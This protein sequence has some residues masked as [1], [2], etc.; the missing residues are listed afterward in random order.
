MHWWILP[1]TMAL[2]AVALLGYIF[3]RGTVRQPQRQP[4]H[5]RRGLLQA[6]LAI[7]EV[8]RI[9]QQVRRNLASHH[10]CVLHFKDHLSDLEAEP[11]EATHNIRHEAEQLLRPTQQLA[12]SMAAAYDE[13][14]QQSDVLMSFAA[15][16]AG[17][18]A[19]REP[20]AIAERRSPTTRRQ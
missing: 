7:A 4:N 15:D 6:Q 2:A 16:G 19:Q 20:I 18:P 12:A 9:A 11:A 13:L 5:N 14:R 1:N 10:L 3:G 17:K 8:G